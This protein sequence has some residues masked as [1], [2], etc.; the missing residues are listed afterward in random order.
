MRTLLLAPHAD[1]ETLFAAFTILKFVPDIA[2]VHVP[3]DDDEQRE[4]MSE[5]RQALVELGVGTA[6]HW[7]GGYEGEQCHS[8]RSWLEQRCP[9]RSIHERAQ[10]DDVVYFD[11]VFAPAVERDGH[12]E[13]NRVGKAALEVFGEDRV[14]SYLTYTRTGGRSRDG[15]EVPYEPEWIAR[16]LCALA[17]YRSQHAHPARAPWF[18]DL[19]DLR[20]WYA[21]PGAPPRP[22]VVKPPATEMRG[23]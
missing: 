14:T 4:R 15:R 17:A 8:L 18:V 7:V 1:D 9:P 5:L 2:V 20:E 6:V 3:R 13:H 10:S 12:V 19:I 11:H 22:P 23:I 16:K 21:E